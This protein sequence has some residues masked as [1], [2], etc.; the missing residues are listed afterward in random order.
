MKRKSG[1]LQFGVISALIL[2]TTVY[3]QDAPEVEAKAPKGYKVVS[4]TYV[5][6]KLADAEV[7]EL[8]HK[9]T[10]C[11]YILQNSNRG[12]SI[13]QMWKEGV[14]VNSSEPYCD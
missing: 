12:T 5:S 6:G 13:E 1:M 10:G 4:R 3:L 14:S 8:K 11:H 9:K 2:G 7:V